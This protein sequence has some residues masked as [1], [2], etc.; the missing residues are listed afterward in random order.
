MRIWAN[1]N[2]DRTIRRIPRR[3]RTRCDGT[4]SSNQRVAVMFELAAALGAGGDVAE[5]PAAV[6]LNRPDR[7]RVHAVRHRVVVNL[8]CVRERRAFSLAW[9]DRT[10]AN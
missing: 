7:E 6:A 8:L 2:H 10:V 1:G 3:S 5:R 4:D 9:R